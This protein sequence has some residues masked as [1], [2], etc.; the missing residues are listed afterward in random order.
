M[1]T[2]DEAWRQV[3]RFRESDTSPKEE[4]VSHCAGDNGLGTASYIDLVACRYKDANTAWTSASDGTLEERVYYCQNQHADVVAIVSSGGAMREW[5]KYSAYGVPFGLPG[6]DTDSDGDCDST[7]VSQIQTWINASHYDVRGDLDL[8]GDVDAA[9]KSLAQASP[10]SGAIGGRLTLSPI[11]QANRGLCG[12]PQNVNSFALARH[13]MLNPSLG[14]WLQRDQASADAPM[15]LYGYCDQNSIL[16]QDPD[17]LLCLLP[18]GGGGG[19]HASGHGH[20]HG[21]SGGWKPRP[22]EFG[23]TEFSEGSPGPCFLASLG[24]GKGAG[25]VAFC[26]NGHAYYCIYYRPCSG[27]GHQSAGACAAEQAFKDCLVQHEQQHASN[28]DCSSSQGNPNPT[29]GGDASGKGQDSETSAYARS[30]EC[31]QAKRDA[32]G[33]GADPDYV[34]NLDHFLGETK[35]LETLYGILRQ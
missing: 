13:R 28:L 3:A 16:G 10:F 29:G 4:F 6:G 31:L 26:Q 34:T 1:N 25:G 24:V 30:R 32:A 20:A 22:P 33:S 2:T 18:G 14:V 12:T 19:G 21:S 7:D 5:V 8:D 35:V 17:G 23:A 9:D 15:S 11:T 27:S